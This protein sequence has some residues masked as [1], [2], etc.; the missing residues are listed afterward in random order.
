MLK[1]ETNQP[2]MNHH[3]ESGLKIE[4]F[5]HMLKEKKPEE[6]VPTDEQIRTSGFHYGI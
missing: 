4:D 1:I 5:Q 2:K 6:K 3:Q